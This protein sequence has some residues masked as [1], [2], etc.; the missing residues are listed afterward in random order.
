MVFLILNL[1]SARKCFKNE[2]G[3]L[4]LKNLTH[5]AKLALNGLVLN[6]ANIAEQSLKLP[7]QDRHLL[8]PP[9]NLPISELYDV[10]NIITIG[11]TPVQA[12]KLYSRLVLKYYDLDRNL[13][14]S[15][16][17]YF[18]TYKISS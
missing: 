17:Q 7:E 18:V 1:I 2:T 3:D 5:E 4:L 16:R 12:R 13:R 10:M 11:R 15:V 6:L 14:V 8:I 9:A